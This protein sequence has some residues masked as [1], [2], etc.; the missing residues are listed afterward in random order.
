MASASV[1]RL[2]RAAGDV[3]LQMASRVHVSVQWRAAVARIDG[4]V[5][6]HRPNPTTTGTQLRGRKP[7][8]GLYQAHGSRFALVRQLE[9]E[10]AH[11]GIRHDTRQP[12]V[13]CHAPDVQVFYDNACCAPH[14]LRTG[15]VPGVTAQA[16][17]LVMSRCQF[18][19]RAL[20]A[21]RRLMATVKAPRPRQ[22]LAVPA[23]LS[24]LGG[25]R[26]RV[27]MRRA[28][29]TGSQGLHAHVHAHRQAAP[30]APLLAWPPPRRRRRTSGR[31]RA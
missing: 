31:H 4:N 3:S 1:L 16:G 13:P 23:D 24:P 7:A 19:P 8:G 2:R 15:L 5:Q 11:A 22:R 20:T 18:A 21:L 12:T 28:V 30:G 14:D 27:G 9:G 17:R 10:I 6:R 25:L 29:R 26:A